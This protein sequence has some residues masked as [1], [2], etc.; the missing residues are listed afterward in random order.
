MHDLDPLDPALRLMFYGWKG[1][2]REA[3]AILASHGL[4]RAH[5]RMLF[6]IARHDGINV[7]DL[8]RALA[9]SVQA[10]QRPMKQLVDKSLVSVTR[11]PSRHRFKS[12]HLTDAGRALEHRASQAERLV[13]GAAFEAVGDTARDGWLAVMREVA[14]AG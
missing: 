8:G 14:L 2:T 3:D 4:G 12:L 7:G 11:H 13:M 5:H 6:V 9:V 1:M 10:M